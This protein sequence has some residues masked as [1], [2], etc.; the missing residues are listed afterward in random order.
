MKQRVTGTL[1]L[2]QLRKLSK[3]TSFNS[4]IS[5]RFMSLSYALTPRFSFASCLVSVADYLICGVQ[6]KMKMWGLLIKN[7]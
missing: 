2:F 5:G 6:C 7:Y 3:M 1:P 4:D